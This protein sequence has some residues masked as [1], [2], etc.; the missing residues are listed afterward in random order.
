LSLH[1]VRAQSDTGI[2]ERADEWREEPSTGSL[3]WATQMLNSG[4]TEPQ[5]TGKLERNDELSPKATSL[6]AVLCSVPSLRPRHRRSRPPGVLY[7]SSA[8][9][10]LRELSSLPTHTHFS[11]THWQNP[12]QTICAH[13][14][15][16]NR[17]G[18]VTLLSALSQLH[19]DKCRLVANL[20][21]AQEAR[22]L[23][24]EI[25]AESVS[26]RYC[27]VWKGAGVL[28]AWALHAS[29]CTPSQH[30]IG[31]LRRRD[32]NTSV[33]V[34]EIEPA[35]CPFSTSVLTAYE[36]KMLDG[37]VA[38]IRADDR[39]ERRRR[40]SGGDNVDPACVSWV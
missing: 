14:Y 33:G 12:T 20:G 25:E 36:T 18:S 31:R 13:E 24:R 17:G 16:H 21:G 3:F 4:N 2:K 35:W 7:V 26:T 23:A 15:A 34:C 28:V 9:R 40:Q 29:K 11:H 22:A 5:A 39:G 1:S 38:R 10:R 30:S 32:G 8:A 19:M 37:G 6:V 27:R